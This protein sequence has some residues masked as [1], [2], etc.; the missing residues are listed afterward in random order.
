MQSNKL[1]SKKSKEENKGYETD[2]SQSAKSLGLELP[3]YEQKQM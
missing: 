2:S 3:D 1:E